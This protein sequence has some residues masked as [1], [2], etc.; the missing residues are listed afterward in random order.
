M[1]RRLTPWVRRL[2]AAALP[3]NLVSS[4]EAAGAGSGVVL[5]R[6]AAT[7]WRTEGHGVSGGLRLCLCDILSR[8]VNATRAS[9]V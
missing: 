4:E 1:R 7:A 2:L 5:G 8:A 3:R 9:Y 6:R